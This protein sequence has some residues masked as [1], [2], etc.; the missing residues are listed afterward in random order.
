LG[1]IVSECG[2]KIDRILWKKKMECCVTMLVYHE[3]Q[4]RG[5]CLLHKSGSVNGS[6]SQTS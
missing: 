1:T 4:K 3:M 2:T 5:H 6:R